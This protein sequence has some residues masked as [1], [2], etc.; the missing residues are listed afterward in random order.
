V[1]P[2]TTRFE[3]KYR[4]EPALG[5]RLRAWLEHYGH[6]QADEHGEGG[7]AAY[8]V[9]SLYLDSPDWS[10]YRDTRNGLF[11]RFKLRART[12]AFTPDASVFLEVKHR[13]GEAMWKTRAGVPRSEA[14]TILEG[15]LPNVKPSAA[16]DNF[17]MQMDL[18]RAYPR[19]WVSYRRHAY[20]G[21]TRDLVRITFD[22]AIVAAP[23]TPRLTEPPRWHLLPE[24]RTLE[25]LELK[26]SGAYPG[27]VGDMIRHFHLNRWSMSKYRQGVDVVRGLPVPVAI[28][29]DRSVSA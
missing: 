6:V 9:H 27:W 5:A 28:P 3:I 23:P 18:R 2:R 12:Y 11:S 21:G 29:S 8:N 19:C 16:L 24:V 14:V 10:I 20:V 15:Q 13:A 26:Y 17:R 1:L 22:T 25:V 7:T 4:I